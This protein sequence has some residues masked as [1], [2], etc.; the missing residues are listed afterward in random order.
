MASDIGISEEFI[1]SVCRQLALNKRVRRQLPGWGRIHI[2]RQ[3]PFLCVYRKPTESAEDGTE[4]LLLG[5]ASYLHASAAPSL[6]KPL[7]EL[8]ARIVETQSAVFGAFLAIELWAQRDEGVKTTAETPPR[9][10]F[11]I[12]APHHDAPEAALNTLE[13]KLVKL[14]LRK[15]QSRV[16][17]RYV[18]RCAPPAMKPLLSAARARNLRCSV[19]GLEVAQVYWDRDTGTVLPFALRAIH[20]GITRV[21]K[22][23][24]YTFAHEHTSHRPAHYHEL[25]RQAMTKAVWD[26]DRRLAQISENFDLLLHVTPVNAADAW[27]VFRGKRYRAIP[28]FH[29]RPRSADPGLLKRALYQ[30]PLDKIEDPTLT[31]L[32]AEKRD[33]LDRQITLFAD[34]G[35]PRFLY[36]SMQLFGATKQP[37]LAAAQELLERVQD[38]AKRG[39]K[40][41]YLEAKA[42]ARRAQVELDY[43]R[44]IDPGLPAQVMIRDDVAGVLV[45]HGHF[46]ISRDVSVAEDRVDATLQHEIGTHVVTYYNGRYQPFQQLYA[47]LAGYEELQ[48]GLAVLSEYLVGGLNPARLRLLAAR[49]I[50]VNSIESGADFIETFRMLKSE[51]GIPPHIAFTVAMRVHR[52]GGYTKDVVYLR[53]LILLLEYIKRKGDL[54]QLLIGKVTLE[55]L[56]LLEELQWRRVLK[57]AKFRPRYLDEPQSATRLQKLQRQPQLLTL[58]EN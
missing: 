2:D 55:Y 47:G 33:E 40:T 44:R 45:S 30:I 31:H 17:V 9:P 13:N 11:R 32:F 14:S 7:T 18:E 8:I 16:D 41:A 51:Y 1:A 56:P 20:T 35:K 37:L 28:E 34:R 23:T 27:Q 15:Q 29:Y 58:L 26:T 25:G 42:F 12:I 53:G 24:F 49:V 50:A 43:Y 46:L 36:G 4:R 10:R 22:Q 3:L 21:L 57:R 52:G 48:E 38:K 54:E 6:Q 5:Q 19:L 39:A